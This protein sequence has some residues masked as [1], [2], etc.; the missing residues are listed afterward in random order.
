MHGSEDCL[1]LSLAMRKLKIVPLH[2]LTSHAT[3]PIVLPL[4]INTI[5]KLWFSIDYV[6]FGIHI[7]YM[8]T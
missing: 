6:Y 1:R 8:T 4:R 2:N 5:Q 7:V 3:I